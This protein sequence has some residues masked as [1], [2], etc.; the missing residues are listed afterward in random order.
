MDTC[1]Y[2]PLS[3]RQRTCVYPH[4]RDIKVV[5][6]ACR[7]VRAECR[8]C[9]LSVPATALD[10]DCARRTAE[11]PSRNSQPCFSS[12]V[13][14]FCGGNASPQLQN[15]HRSRRLLVVTINSSSMSEIL[16]TD[17]CGHKVSN[18][19][20]MPSVAERCA[21][22]IRD[23]FLRTHVRLFRRGAIGDACRQAAHII[24][25]YIEIEC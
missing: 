9:M 18:P 14:F 13:C 1:T 12:L 20:Q 2:A 25:C 19:I 24:Q 23:P 16:C 8:T 17:I 22:R 15:W 21:A 6:T 7:T 5:H 10:L 4:V 11:I 3:L